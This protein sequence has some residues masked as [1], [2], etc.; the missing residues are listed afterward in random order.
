[1]SDTDPRLA[2]VYAEALRSITQQQGVLEQLRSNAGTLLAALSLA[3]GFLAGL[4]G[5]KGFGRWGWIA[6]GAFV[7]AVV[8]VA[9][10]LWPYKWRFRLKTGVLLDGYVDAEPP[11]SLDVM[12]R[13][14]AEWL[15]RDWQENKDRLRW[16]FFAFEVATVMLVFEIVSWIIDLRRA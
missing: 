1:V 11:T 3:T 7:V 8:L 15:E 9:V 10:I 2:L 6:T 13:K 5:Q 4:D 12:H 14:L 16:M